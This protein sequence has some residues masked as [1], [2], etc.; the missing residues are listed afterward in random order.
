MLSIFL[1]WLLAYIQ[2]LFS[3][4]GSRTA[5]TCFLPYSNESPDFT[6]LHLTAPFRS[7]KTPHAPFH[8]GIRLERV[9][10]TIKKLIVADRLTRFETDSPKIEAWP[11]L[12]AS[13]DSLVLSDLQCVHQVR[14]ILWH[15]INRSSQLSGGHGLWQRN[16]T[17][18]ETKL[19][20]LKRAIKWT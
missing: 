13:V 18:S 15:I 20:D 1:L 3:A 12:V 2:I 17:Q 5:S 7:S 19:T 4:L 16:G 14:E 8:F 9:K 6:I 11:K 10:K